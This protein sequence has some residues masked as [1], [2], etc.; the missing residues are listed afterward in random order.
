VAIHCNSPQL[1]PTHYDALQLTVELWARGEELAEE[2][3]V[4]E[5]MRRKISI[6]QEILCV[7]PKYPRYAG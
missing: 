6:G 4:E 3:E 1:A 2:D 7:R 5:K